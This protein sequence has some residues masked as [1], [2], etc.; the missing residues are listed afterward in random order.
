MT[1]FPQRSR[2]L[3]VRAGIDTDAAE[4]AI[5]PPLYLSSTYSF[6]GF[7]EPR[8]YDY[9]RCGNP[10]RDHVGEAIA[11]LEGGAG[12]TITPSGLASVTLVT[13]LL[14]RPTDTVL[15]AHDCYG[16]TWRLFDTL[17]EHGTLR[18]R[19]VDLSDLAALEAALA[20]PDAPSVVWVETPSNP[21]LRVT[22]IAAVSELAHRFGATVVVDNT[23]LSPALQRPFEH[24]ADL[25]IHSTTKFLN[26][27]SDVVGGAV[28]ARTQEQHEEL[29]ELANVLGLVG[30]AFDSYLTLRG[31]RTL[32]TRL[33]AHDESARA[34]LAEVVDHPAV[35]AVHHPSLPDHPGHEIAARQ[36]DGFGSMLSIDLAG[37]L[38]AVRA[39][40]D[41][42]R[43]LSL[44]ESLGG[45]ESLVAHPATMT[46]LS[47]TP[48]AR[49]E[50][51]IGDGLLRLSLGI[52]DPEDLRA[53]VRAA[54]DRAAAATHAAARVAV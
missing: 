52:E 5:I 9:S 42:L 31:I 4:G 1:D 32:H 11:A 14:L 53:D 2:T 19:T 21:L 24:G 47:M 6:A 20:D 22:D 34:V 18:Y 29:Q 33:R 10:T 26:G 51:G 54:L 30:S 36:Q 41:G 39:F 38:P 44:A 35:A 23:F 3:A 28:V 40:L 7:D 25:V 46:H 8:R 27:H 43:C 13:H 16:G 15:V 45:T 48:E 49:A 50:A 12:A 17:A 37:G